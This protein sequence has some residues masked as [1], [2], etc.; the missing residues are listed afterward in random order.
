MVTIC[1]AGR[2]LHDICTLVLEVVAEAKRP[3]QLERNQD[4]SAQ[5][6][7]PEPDEQDEQDLC[8]ELVTSIEDTVATN[9]LIGIAEEAASKHTP[10]TADTM[11]RKG[12]HDVIDLESG[13]QQR[14]SN[15]QQTTDAANDAGLPWLHDCASSSDGDETSQDAIAKGTD[16]EA[17]R[18]DHFGPEEKHQQACHT[19]RE[20]GVDGDDAGEVSSV[21]VVHGSGAARV[22]TIP[23]EPKAERAQDTERDAVSVELCGKVRIPSTLSGSDDDGSK[24]SPDATDQMHD[25]TASEVDHRRGAS[26]SD[27]L[28][29]IIG[30]VEHALTAPGPPDNDRVDQGSHDDSVEG[31]AF[32]LCPLGHGS[33]NNGAPS[34]AESALE[35]PESELGLVEPQFVGHEVGVANEAVGLI[36]NAKGKC[37]SEDIPAQEAEGNHCQILREDVLGV[38][39]AN[40]SSLQQTETSMHEEDQRRCQKHPDG[41]Q[42]LFVVS[43]HAVNSGLLDLEFGNHVSHGSVVEIGSESHVAKVGLTGTSCKRQRQ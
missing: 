41:V 20:C 19:R 35:E 23:S 26:E 28:A 6:S 29:L 10:H 37:I 17:F 30:V 2:V 22:K 32:K 43:L 8:P 42:R 36:R 38:L 27:G 16:V 5:D 33:T 31:K 3:C 11:D 24:D 18:L 39:E 13:Q 1:L 25:A 12:V 21:R 7:N 34:G 14:S 4:D 9:A 15:I 40:G